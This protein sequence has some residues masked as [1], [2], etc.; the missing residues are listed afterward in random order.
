MDDSLTRRS[1]LVSGSVLVAG[2][3]GCLSGATFSAADDPETEVDEEGEPPDPEVTVA[4]DTA[5]ATDVTDS[6]ATFVGEVVELEGAD[7][8][9]VHFDWRGET[10]G[11]WNET[12]SQVLESPGSFSIGSTGFDRNT[13]YEFRAVAQARGETDVGETRTFTTETGIDL[14]VETGQASEVTDS[15][16]TLVGEVTELDGLEEAIV[17]FEWRPVGSEEWTA[18]GTESRKSPT[19][20]QHSLSGLE[21]ETAY[22]F[23]AVA[24]ADGESIAATSDLSS[25]TTTEE[26]EAV[27][28][29][30]V[31]VKD[32]THSNAVFIGEVTHLDQAESV[33][34]HFEWREAGTEA[35]T[36][37]DVETVDTPE[38]FRHPIPGL[39]SETAY[40]FR[41]VADVDGQTTVGQLLT[42]TSGE[43]VPIS[44][45]D[46]AEPELSIETFA[47]TEVTDSAA[48][49][50]AELTELDGADSATVGFEWRESG[51]E[52]WW[53]TEMETRKSTGTVDL[54]MSGLDPEMAYEF[55][56]IA[57][58]D[59][60]TDRGDVRSFVTT[61]GEAK[62]DQKS[63]E[64]DQE[65][66]EG[67]QELVYW[68][69]DFGAGE[70]PPEPPRYYPDDVVA[71]LG[72]SADGVTENP[73]FRRKQ[74][75]G[76]LGDV[77]VADGSVS[78][79]DSDDPT[80]VSVAFELD[81][82]APERHLH[83]AVF[84][85]PGPYDPAEVDEQELYEYA[86]AT[87]GGGDA[88][89][90]SVSVPQ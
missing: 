47:A 50:A 70:K 12:S 31:E 30:T 65:S 51:T 62:E 20:F 72:N 14:A 68:Q 87:Y 60:A 8:T 10:D 73:S 75:D 2:T 38:T 41:A 54:R 86:S 88:G 58:A 81:E 59:D 21:S 89:E 39:E 84:V 64:E 4:V 74:T 78:F 83:L 25:F 69:V 6:A 33:D 49:L 63:G 32:V 71:A 77:R 85:M 48:R 76:Q 52:T 5:E 37:S 67:D 26:P 43:Y 46:P 11:E 22:E 90:L 18:S 42:F 55:R 45:D 56:A 1:A 23:R 24:E 19:T 82:G 13:P 40:E 34:V 44:S 35:W 29:E 16:V 3:S 53:T 9:S 61:G 7:S 36:T 57:D 79:A 27:G 80:E 15:T 17:G 66:S 28:I